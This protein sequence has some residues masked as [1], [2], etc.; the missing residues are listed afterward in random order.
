MVKMAYTLRNNMRTW[1]IERL[2]TFDNDEL[3]NK[4]TEIDLTPGCEV[5][6]VIYMGDS[7]MHVRI[8]Q[9][10]YVED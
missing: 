6:E 10:I 5:K 1:K 7:P 8:Y 2:V 4:L 3:A 9:I